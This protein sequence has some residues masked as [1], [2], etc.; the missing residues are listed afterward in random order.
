MAGK[1]QLKTNEADKKFL[2]S[3]GWVTGLLKL[4]FEGDLTTKQKQIVE[5]HLSSIDQKLDVVQNRL[6]E[7]Q[8]NRSGKRIK[9]QVFSSLNLV[10]PENKLKTIN[11]ANPKQGIKLP[12][13]GIFRKYVAVAAIF[14]FIIGASYLIISQRSF[15]QNDHII[16]H[17]DKTPVLQTGAS[18]IK[19]NI[20]PD[21]TKLYVNG[22]TRIDYIKNHFNK[23]K[24]EIW[25]E[26]EVFFDVAKNPEKPFIIHS[27][28]LQTVVRGTSFNVKAYKE[29]GEISVSVKSGKVEVGTNNNTFG[30]LTANRELIYNEKTHEHTIN[31]A[32]WEE[33]VAWREGRLILK[34]ANI[35]ELKIRMKQLYAVDI[36]VEGN[37]LDNERFGL[38]FQKGATLTD[39]METISELY[40]VKYKETG[41]GEVIIHPNN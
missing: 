26:G 18:E 1:G 8:L 40:E 9:Q 15:F 7:R 39:V 31:E 25:I 16:S 27:G 36:I 10:Y 21:G 19:E 35:A 11:L 4:Y 41:I 24:R 20:L 23:E 14:I 12:E 22:N 13:L 29:I 32:N 2:R 17:A 6:T 38:S 34:N 33:S 5:Q 30:L 37:F 28:N 3:L